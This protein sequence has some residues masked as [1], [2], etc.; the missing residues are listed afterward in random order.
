[1]LVVKQSD[2]IIYRGSIVFHQRLPHS[3]RS[4]QM[5]T[6]YMHTGTN[7]ELHIIKPYS[8]AKLQLLHPPK[9]NSKAVTQAIP[10]KGL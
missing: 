2:R 4:L 10:L 3:N 1:M 8:H 7:H 5:F 9:K 6:H